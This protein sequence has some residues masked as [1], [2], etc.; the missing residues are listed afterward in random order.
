MLALS[1]V[2]APPAWPLPRVVAS[3]RAFDVRGVAL[4][5]P[6]EAGEAPA[7]RRLLPPPRLVAVFGDAPGAAVGAPLLVVEGVPAGADREEALLALCRRLHALRPMAVAIRAGEDPDG[8]PA[9]PEL[10]LLFSELAHLRYWHDAARAGEAWLHAAGARLA[11]ASLDPR[12]H[13]DL[14]GLA[15][16]LGRTRPAVVACPPGTP[17]RDVIEAVRRAQGCFRA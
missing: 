10:P 17:K 4:H 6:P 11:G 8:L 1:T 16:A 7:L 5:R 14:A 15:G 13:L 12:E 9:A 2:C 3:F